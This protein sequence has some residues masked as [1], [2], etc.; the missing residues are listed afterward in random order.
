MRPIKFRA[1]E[2]YRKKFIYFDIDEIVG[3]VLEEDD[4]FNYLR[5]TLQQYTGLK[6]KNGKEIYEGDIVKVS[7]KGYVGIVH[8]HKS[9]YCIG[10]PNTETHLHP[11][12]CDF[13]ML[14]FDLQVIGN[15]HE[16]PE[17]IE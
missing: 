13:N 6:D 8:W 2:K 9:R 12:S 11:Y 14:A 7:D 10:K 16:N 5:D 15:I 17:V 4:W 3:G 1:W